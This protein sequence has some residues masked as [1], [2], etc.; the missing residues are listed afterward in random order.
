[1]VLFEEVKVIE[2]TI[3]V[4]ISIVDDQIDYKFILSSF[5]SGVLGAVIE[6]D[7]ISDLKSSTDYVMVIVKEEDSAAVII[8]KLK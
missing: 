4:K 5:V 2:K 3:S 1:M 6:N 8:S 7:V